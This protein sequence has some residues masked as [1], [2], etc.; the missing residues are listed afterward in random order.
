MVEWT[1]ARIA[2]EVVRLEHTAALQNMVF[3]LED[4]QGGGGKWSKHHA[5]EGDKRGGISVGASLRK[6]AKTHLTKAQGVGC[7]RVSDSIGGLT[8]ESLDFLGR[9]AR[10]IV[11]DPGRTR[12][13]RDQGGLSEYG[14]QA[15][16]HPR[17][18]QAQPS[19]AECLDRGLYRSPCTVL[20]CHAIR[21][22]ARVPICPEQPGPDHYR[23]QWAIRRGRERRADSWRNGQ[24]HPGI[25]DE[26]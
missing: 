10:A 3:Y 12:E 9:I 14:D 1:D 23:T 4:L 18:Q 21:C 22:H 7:T 11:A 8:P 19:R 25:V 15:S 24:L 17:P 13:E 5:K 26:V 20:H 2:T 6:T 16:V